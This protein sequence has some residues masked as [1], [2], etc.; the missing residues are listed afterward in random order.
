MGAVCVVNKQLVARTFDTSWMAYTLFLQTYFNLVVV[1][2]LVNMQLCLLR[3]D[4]IPVVGPRGVERKNNGFAK[5]L[6]ELACIEG[7]PG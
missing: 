1:A 2:L 3:C 7:C 6:E 4:E 5:G